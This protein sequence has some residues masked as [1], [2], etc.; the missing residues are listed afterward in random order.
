MTCGFDKQA[1]YWKIGTASQLIFHGYHNY[2]IDCVKAMTNDSFITGGQDGNLAM[3]NMKR[4]KPIFD[5]QQVHN[6][7][8]VTC[9]VRN[10]INIKK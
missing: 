8:W 10:L 4:K 5:M 3:W 6:G 1:I 2:S 9:L 7:E